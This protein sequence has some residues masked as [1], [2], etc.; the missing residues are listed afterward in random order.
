MADKNFKVKNGLDIGD[1]IS[2]YVTR[3]V[4]NTAEETMLDSVLTGTTE[5]IDYSLTLYQGAGVIRKNILAVENGVGASTQ[6]YGSV[7]V[8]REEYSGAWTWTTR[9]SNFGAYDYI[10]SI[11]YGN[12]LW[13]VTGDYGQIR[14]ST[15]GTTWTT[16]TSNFGTTQINSVAYGNGVFIVAGSAGQ[17]RTS[18]DGISWFTQTSNFGTTQIRSVAYGNSLWVAGGENGQLRTENP[19][20]RAL[21]LTATVPNAMVAGSEV[22]AILEKETFSA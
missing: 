3:V 9:T 8:N 18:W 17:I 7:S 16:Q 19:A 10:N 21:K 20:E 14:T 5:M 11:A 4:I 22:T 2:T 6:E 13:V 15:D 1:N 12:N